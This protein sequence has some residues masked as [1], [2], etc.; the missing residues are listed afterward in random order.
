MG[1]HGKYNKH[2]RE[3]NMKRRQ[4]HKKFV[5]ET[6]TRNDRALEKLMALVE[7]YGD[8]RQGSGRAQAG[9]RDTEYY[10]KKAQ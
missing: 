8:L 10:K 5:K 1:R 7:Y 3:I 6:T 9:G 4:Q 2:T